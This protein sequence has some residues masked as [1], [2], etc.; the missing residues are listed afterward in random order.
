MIDAPMKAKFSGHHQNGR[1]LYGQKE[2]TSSYSVVGI[3]KGEIVSPVTVRVWMGRSSNASTV[4]ASVWLSG[5][6]DSSF[7]SSGHG[8]AGG[9]GYCKE[10]TAIGEALHSAG[11]TLHRGN[12]RSYIGGV[13]SYAIRESLEAI[14]KGLGIRSKIRIIE[15]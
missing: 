14:A 3:Y 12:D 5:V 15:N 7:H 8:T 1:N 6:K 4:Y 13:G 11:I 2:Q 9:Y 10:S